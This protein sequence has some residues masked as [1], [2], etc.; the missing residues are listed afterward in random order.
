MERGGPSE[1]LAADDSEDTHEEQGH[2]HSDDA[3][4]SCHP[5]HLGD[6]GNLGAADVFGR[7]IDREHNQDADEGTDGAGEDEAEGLARILVGMAR[8]IEM[9]GDGIGQFRP[10]PCCHDPQQDIQHEACYFENR[11]FFGAGHADAVSWLGL[12]KEEGKQI[13]IDFV[14][15]D[16][17]R[18]VSSAV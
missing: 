9:G 2:Q 5:Y 12:M 1:R 11:A 10:H 13:H 8:G 16:G 4:S 15:S 17:E 18:I 3:Q 7:E 14:D 6:V